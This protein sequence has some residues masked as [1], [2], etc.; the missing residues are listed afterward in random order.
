MDSS[1]GHDT[2]FLE[3]MKCTIIK[4]LSVITV[5]VCAAFS[6]LRT[7]GSRKIAGPRSSADRLGRTAAVQSRGAASK[8]PSKRPAVAARKAK[9]LQLLASG[10]KSEDADAAAPLKKK[11][12][13]IALAG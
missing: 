6:G 1:S 2:P 13:R 5:N 12:K 3:D 7:K 11:L 9:Q 8:R 4:R 10:R